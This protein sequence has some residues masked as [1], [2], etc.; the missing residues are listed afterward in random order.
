MS[1]LVAREE[2]AFS[3]QGEH[4]IGDAVLMQVHEGAHGFLPGREGLAGQLGNLVLVGL[5]EGRIFLY[6]GDQ[7]APAGVDQDGDGGGAAAG[8]QV[9]VDVFRGALRDAA[10]DRDDPGTFELP[11]KII[12]EAGYV[13]AGHRGTGLQ[14]LGGFIVG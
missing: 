13:F 8:D 5:D 10:G 2:G 3:T 4:D 9:A 6:G 7:A 12:E 1:A 14:V 11:V